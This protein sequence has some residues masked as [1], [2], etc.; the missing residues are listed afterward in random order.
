MHQKTDEYAEIFAN[1]YRAAE[2]GFIDEVILP[3]ETRIKLIKGFQML[4]NKPRK[5]GEK[6]TGWMRNANRSLASVLPNAQY[7]TLEGQT[8]MLKPKAHAPILMDFFKDSIKE[9]E[10]QCAS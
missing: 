2:R 10:G 8:H 6:S 7:R 5:A 9:G 4:E 3:E 1:P